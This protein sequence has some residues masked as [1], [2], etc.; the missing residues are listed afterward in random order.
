MDHELFLIIP[1]RRHV[2]ITLS[3]IDKMS[4]QTC[5]FK[6]LGEVN[7]MGLFGNRWVAVRTESGAR[8]DDID[9]LDAWFKSHG[10]KSKVTLEGTIKRIHVRKN[11]TAQAAELMVAFDKER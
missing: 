8:A 5:A 7:A 1:I 9:R 2:S 4:L 11:D 3:N 10:L 6:S